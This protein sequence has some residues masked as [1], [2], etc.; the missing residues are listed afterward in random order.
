[1]TA[2]AEELLERLHQC[3][4]GRARVESAQVMQVFAEVVPH[5]RGRADAREELIRLL[6]VLEASGALVL[7][8][9]E[10][11]YDR[12]QIPPLPRW[13]K[14]VRPEKGVGPLGRAREVPWHPALAFVRKL[15]QLSSSQLE[16]LEAIQAF[17][18]AA[19]PDEPVLTVRER[20]LLL[21]GDDK[22]LENLAQ[23][24]L[25]RPGRISWA[26]LRCR[27]VHAPFVHKDLG[28]GTVALIIENK[29]T[30][31]SAVEALGSAGGPV[32][33][34][35]YGAGEMIVQS[36]A[37]MAEWHCRPS[38]LLYFGDVDAKGLAIVQRA[39]GTAEVEKL[40]AL[41]PAS[42]LYQPLVARAQMTECRLE[43]NRVSGADAQRLAA[44]LP[45]ALQPIVVLALQQGWRWPQE[46]VTARDIAR[47]EWT[48]SS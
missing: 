3:S 14:L 11:G 7:P 23:G 17:L 25:F 16:A 26:L 41:E 35:I 43:G 19:R 30:F 13:V 1:M 9:G 36:L 44:W 20:S 31:W 4:R 39:Q 21:F 12:V 8:K 18:A 24:A 5:L 40:P 32:R 33:W 37:S 42:P 38:R 22:R 46:F 29:D 6:A 15:P 27:P 10:D 28:T 47:A 34:V 2:W 48:A 45:L